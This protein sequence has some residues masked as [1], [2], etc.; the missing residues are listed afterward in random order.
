MCTL[1][2]VGWLLFLFV[3]CLLVALS[4]FL[5]GWLQP[6]TQSALC[7]YLLFSFVTWCL[8]RLFCF[9]LLMG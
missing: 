6:I 9:D 1:L 4:V 8:Y 2:V 7:L 3:C 5:V